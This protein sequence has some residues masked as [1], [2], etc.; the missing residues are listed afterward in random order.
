[1]SRQSR[2]I[3]TFYSTLYVTQQTWQPS[4][5][6]RTQVNRLLLARFFLYWFGSSKTPVIQCKSQGYFVW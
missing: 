4:G 6:L 1:M 5:W 3:H 2:F